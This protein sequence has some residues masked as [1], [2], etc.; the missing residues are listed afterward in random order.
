MRNETF[1]KAQSLKRD[2]EN[3]YR[4]LNVTVDSICDFNNHKLE[5]NR[6][7]IANMALRDLLFTE[8]ETQFKSDFTGFLQKELDIYKLNFEKL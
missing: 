3:I 4:L 2:M 6:L 7:Q 5:I 1:N 8:E